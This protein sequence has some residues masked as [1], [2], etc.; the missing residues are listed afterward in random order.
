MN[1]ADCRAILG[2]AAAPDMS[3]ADQRALGLWRRWRKQYERRDR[4]GVMTEPQSEDA[5][6]VA[7]C[8]GI[9][10]RVFG[11]HEA[12]GSCGEVNDLIVWFLREGLPSVDL[13]HGDLS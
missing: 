11:R 4:R 2:A 13:A 3:P 7:T 10:R 5:G 12:I 8:V 6:P 1:A 9:G